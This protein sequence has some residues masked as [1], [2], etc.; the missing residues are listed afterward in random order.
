VDDRH[1]HFADDPDHPAVQKNGS[2]SKRA[3]NGEI[4]SLVEEAIEKMKEHGPV[5]L[6]K[7]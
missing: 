2:G 1:H 7:P 3:V 5:S 6:G 4:D